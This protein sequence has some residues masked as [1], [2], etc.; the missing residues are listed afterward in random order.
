MNAK[1]NQKF[2]FIIVSAMAALA[3]LACSLN[4][5]ATA[6]ATATDTPVPPPTPTSTPSPTAVPATATAAPS[7]TVEPPTAT[8]TLTPTSTIILVIAG[9]DKKIG[10]VTFDG[11]SLPLSQ[12]P[13]SV[14]ALATLASDPGA[15]SKAYSIGPQGVTALTFVNNSSEG[16]ASFTGASAPQGEVAWDHW[17]T[18]AASGTVNSDIF[19]ANADGSNLRSVLQLSGDHVLHVVRFSPD[20]QRLYYSQEPLGLGGYIPFSGVSDLYALDLAGGATTQLVPDAAAGVIC[21]DDFAPDAGLVALHC[22]PKTIDVLDT[23]TGGIGQ[24]A[25]PAA[26]TDWQLHGDARLS[27]D[28]T[29]VAY[30][31]ARGNPDNEQ[32][33]VAVSDGL[34]GTSHLVAT[35]PAADY[36]SVKGW[37]NDT[38]LVLQSWGAKPGVWVVQ[39]DGS[40]L[41]RLADGIF[42]GSG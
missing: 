10:L 11:Q 3:I 9:P 4:G 23:T 17:A 19:V 29:R 5:S 36:F 42:L 37:L 27:P 16:F 6:T 12:A 8:A 39:S 25:P 32:G 13:G 21:L 18:T 26:V 1:R 38:T 28:Q 30:A 2:A 40:D 31:L 14:Y 33:W 34:T 15:P 41:R 22:A 35:S 7:P 20:G 24:V